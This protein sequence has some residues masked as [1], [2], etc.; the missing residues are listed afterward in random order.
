MRKKVIL[1]LLFCLS[2]WNSA[3]QL[4]PVMGATCSP[5]LLTLSTSFIN[6]SVSFSTFVCLW[7]SYYT[8]TIIHPS[9][10]QAVSK[11]FLFILGL[12]LHNFILRKKMVYIRFKTFYILILMSVIRS[13]GKHSF[14]S[15]SM[16]IF[17][18]FFF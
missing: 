10:F 9:S 16:I 7:T 17:S 3:H 13:T 6:F 11:L 18:L 12:L 1:P 2:F 15:E 4:L 14:R 8:V 5:S